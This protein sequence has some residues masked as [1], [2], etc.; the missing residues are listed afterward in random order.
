M[1]IKKES[2]M[3][4]SSNQKNLKINNGLKKMAKQYSYIPVKTKKNNQSHRNQQ[5][6]LNNNSKCYGS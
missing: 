3:F 4:N 6:P 2:N 1:K 5:I